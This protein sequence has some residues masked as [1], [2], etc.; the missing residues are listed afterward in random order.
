LNTT[1][2]DFGYENGQWED[3]NQKLNALTPWAMTGSGHD[4][5]RFSVPGALGHPLSSYPQVESYLL[6]YFVHAIVPSCSLSESYN[7]YLSLVTQIA[8]SHPTLKNTL[9]A[10]S[11]N[12]LQLLGD[13]RFVKEAYLYKQM[14]LKGLQD[15]INE[16]KPSHGAVA[17][18]LMLCFHDV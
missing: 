6:T 13:R 10:I 3:R 1:Y 15:E 2:W 18:V 17:T 14:A 11:A 12:Q 4:S 16:K 9:L 8:F 7:P 5:S